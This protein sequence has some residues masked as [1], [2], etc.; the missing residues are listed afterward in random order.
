MI[1][2]SIFP[3]TWPTVPLDEVCEIL[4]H[5]R[6]PITQ[7]DR[8]SGPYPYYGANGQQDS[9]HEYIFDEPLVLVA[10]D[11]GHFGSLEKTI[12]YKV[13]GKC[14]VNNHA[15]VLRAKP[16]ID[17]DFLCRC[18]E[19]YDVTPF[20]NGSTR[21]KLTKGSLCKI[22]IPLPPLSEQKRIAE[23]LDCADAIRRTRQ[24]TLKTCD[25]LLRSTFLE[26]FGDPVT[27]PMGWE[28]RELGEVLDFL[29][30]GSRGWAKYY[31]S[32]GDL[33]LRIQNVKGSRLKLDDVVFVNA[34]D[35][36]EAKRTKV[37]YGD[38]LLSITADLGRTA[39]IGE[40]CPVAYINQHLAILRVNKD[41]LNPYFLS[42]FLSTEGGRLQFATLNKGGVKAGLNFNDIKSLKILVPP[43][44]Q[45]FRAEILFNRQQ[46]LETELKVSTKQEDTLF[47][48]LVQRAFRG[49]L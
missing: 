17:I 39:V 48:S 22:Q 35:S 12:A 41:I 8:V 28:V 40:D 24:E 36:A 46:E 5:L 9:V 15:H 3:P 45:Q 44:E 42:L 2:A 31:S 27:N 21:Q 16:T 32:S 37:E 29:T 20:I 25:E 13:T 7:K 19:R 49:E 30:S 14:W 11:G 23:I 10:E 1:R 26:I 38:V 43:T 6:K 18:L 47:N 33:F 4:D 34:P